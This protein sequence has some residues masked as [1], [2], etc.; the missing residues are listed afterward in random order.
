MLTG[1]VKHG[2]L[3]QLAENLWWTWGSL[4]GMSLRRSMVI[5]RRSDGD[6]VVHNPIFLD[7][8]GMRTLEEIGRPRYLVVPN[9]EYPVDPPAFK[10]R[11]P[12]LQI[13]APRGGRDGVARIVEVDGIYEDFPVDGDV[14]LE[15]LH[16][17]GDEEGALVVSSNDGVTLVLDDAIIDTSRKRDPFRF[18]LRTFLGAPH[19]PARA[20]IA[21]L[22]RQFF[23]K[24]KSALREDLERFAEIPELVRLVATRIRRGEKVAKGAAA[25]RAL[26]E[27]A[28]SLS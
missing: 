7:D 5:A 25:A 17:V 24:N 15:M 26:K 1:G 16:G 13:F 9:A 22:F 12:E 28:A 8:E 11:F 10:E 18:L 27:A 2:N 20:R 23:V 19:S 14:Q 21:R 3:E 4:P 6:L